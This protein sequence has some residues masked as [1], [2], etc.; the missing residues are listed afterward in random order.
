MELCLGMDDQPAEHLQVGIRRHTSTDDVVV[1]VC[2]RPS[3]QEDDEAL[4][5]QLEKVSCSQTLVLIRNFSHPS[6]YWRDNTARHKQSMQF[7]KVHQ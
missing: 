2:Y 6:I 1:D 3:D 4:F 7:L 5:R